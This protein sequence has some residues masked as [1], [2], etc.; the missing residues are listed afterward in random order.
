MSGGVAVCDVAVCGSFLC[1]DVLCF[2][3]SALCCFCCVVLFFGLLRCVVVAVWGVDMGVAVWG[4]GIGLRTYRGQDP[5][6]S[7]QKSQYITK[8]NISSL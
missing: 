8:G 6:N 4:V 7:P 5:K 2:S 1:V 3:V